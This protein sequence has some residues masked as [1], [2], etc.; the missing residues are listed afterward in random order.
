MKNPG[1]SKYEPKPGAP[2]SHDPA[3]PTFSGVAANSTGSR[4]PNGGTPSGVTDQVLLGGPG[5][6]SEP[7]QAVKFADAT[8]EPGDRSTPGN[9]SAPGDHST[10]GDNSLPGDESPITT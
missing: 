8:Q 4:V 1:L 7:T 9:E 10:P 3:S 5:P 2:W 6:Y